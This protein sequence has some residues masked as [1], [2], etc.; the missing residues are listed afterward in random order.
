MSRVNIHKIKKPHIGAPALS[1]GLDD[2]C[3]ETISQLTDKYEREIRSMMNAIEKGEE[4]LI[5]IVRQSIIDVITLNF[6]SISNFI[7]IT[8][9]LTKEEID[10]PISMTASEATFGAW[11]VGKDFMRTKPHLASRFL[12]KETID[13]ND[14]PHDEQYLL[15]KAAYLPY[16]VFA[17]IFSQYYKSPIGR[18][19]KHQEEGHFGDTYESIMK[20]VMACF[21]DGIQS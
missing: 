10:S 15:I 9:T 8:Y 13:L 12:N 7:K 11:C 18:I 21:L 14:I 17:I 6:Q 4:S 3:R 19:T 1:P 5:I 16:S 20:G 2:D